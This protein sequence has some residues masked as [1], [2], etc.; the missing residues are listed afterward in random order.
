MVHQKNL[1]QKKVVKGNTEQQKMTGDIQKTNRR[2]KSVSLTL[3][4]ISLNVNGI[5]T[6]SKRHSLVE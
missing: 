5:N 3:L 6:P 4:L 1:T 2:Y